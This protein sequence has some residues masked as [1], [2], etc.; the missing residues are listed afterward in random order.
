MLIVDEFDETASLVDTL[1][2]EEGFESTQARSTPELMRALDESRPDL[3]LLEVGLVERAV[4]ELIEFLGTTY[5]DISI[6]AVAEDPQAALLA[7]KAGA[8]FAICKPIDYHE[9]K[10]AVR[11]SWSQSYDG[12]ARLRK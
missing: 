5:P 6:I 2:N 10:N 9:M 12:S 11:M 8:C 1:S 7:I 4:G 3:L